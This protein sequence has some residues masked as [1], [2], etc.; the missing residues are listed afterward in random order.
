M[1]APAC[2]KAKFISLFLQI[3]M[4]KYPKIKYNSLQYC[5]RGISAAGSAPHW[6]C[7]GQGF[8]SPM[9]HQYKTPL[10]L[11]SG[12]LYLRSDVCLTASDVPCG[13]DVAYACDVFYAHVYRQH[14]ITASETDYWLELLH[15]TN[16]IDEE[17]L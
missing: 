16:Q 1:R 12:V 11:Q 15:R 13:S 8:K 10:L 3:S 14:C 7:G 6:Q 2:G 4:D 5:K 9:L 17:N